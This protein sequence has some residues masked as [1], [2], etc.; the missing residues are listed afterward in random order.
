MKMKTV[1]IACGNYLLNTLGQSKLA[2]YTARS[3]LLPTR[4][5]G[6]ELKHIS[7]IATTQKLTTNSINLTNTGGSASRQLQAEQL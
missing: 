2:A 6:F 5:Y 1:I 4:S 3:L 7:L